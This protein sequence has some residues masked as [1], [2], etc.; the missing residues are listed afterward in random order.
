M[1]PRYDFTASRRADQWHEVHCSPGE[2]LIV[3]GIHALH[4]E[5]TGLMDESKVFR[6]YVSARTK[7]MDGAEEGLIPKQLRLIRRMV[8]DC[9]FRNTPP[10]QTLFFWENVCAGEREYI[11]PYRDTADYK[12]D[13]SMDYEPGVYRTLLAP[14]LE[15]ELAM[16]VQHDG[17]ITFAVEEQSHDEL[18]EELL[19][20]L[21]RFEPLPEDMI[22]E[23]S[24]VREFIGL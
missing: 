19:R 12:I 9:K 13:S 17:D 4:P 5:I 16:S 6:V 21:N 23:N 20:D 8:R 15:K 24:V 18:L 14:F 2:I 1:L 7:Y 22:P 3:E 11:N 10:A